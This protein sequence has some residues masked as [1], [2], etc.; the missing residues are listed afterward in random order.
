MILEQRK[1][2]VVLFRHPFKNDST[3]HEVECASFRKIYNELQLTLPID[4]YLF[5]DGDNLVSN[6]SKIPKSDLVYIRAT[7]RGEGGGSATEDEGKDMMSGGVAAWLLAPLTGPLAVVFAIGGMITTLSGYF[8]Y[9]RPGEDTTNIGGSVSGTQ[10]PSIK[11]GTNAIRINQKVPVLL[12][13][14][15]V[16]PWYGAL[17][18]ASYG[19][20]T[21]PGEGFEL[22]SKNQYLNMLFGNTYINADAHL[23]SVYIGEIPYSSY[24]ELDPTD[25]LIEFREDG[26]LPTYYPTRI[27]QD[28]AN[29]LIKRGNTSD[30]PDP[31]EYTRT[32]AQNTKTADLIFVFPTGVFKAANGAPSQWRVGIKVEWKNVEDP[33]TS[34]QTIVDD[35]SYY[36]AVE[37]RRFYVSKTFDNNTPASSEWNSLRQYTF[38]IQRTT[39]DDLQDNSRDPNHSFNSTLYLESLQSYTGTYDDVS[40]PEDWPILPSDQAKLNV[41]SL[42]VKA[43]DQIS[44]EV[45]NVNYEMTAHMPVYT[46]NG[47]SSESGPAYW[48]YGTS[49][50]PASA[51]LYILTS[52]LANSEPIPVANLEERID[53]ESLEVWYQFCEDNE[54]ECN[55]YLVN[56]MTV[57]NVL[58]EICSVGFASWNVIDNRYTIY[59]DTYNNTIT[60]MFTPRN[61]YEYRG[62]KAFNDVP[63]GLK[64]TFVNS[65]RESTTA[66]SEKSEGGFVEEVR[67]VYYD[68]YTGDPRSTDIIH[69]VSTFGAMDPEQ[70]WRIGMYLLA[71]TRLRPETH[72][73]SVDIEHIMCT[74]WDRVVLQH[75]VP[76]FGLTS[77][78]ILAPIESAGDTLGFTSDEIIQFEVGKNYGI[79]VRW[80]DGTITNYDVTNTETDTH[81]ILFETPVTGTGLFFQD[82]LFLIGERG[83]ESIDLLI[84]DIEA[85][86]DHCARITCMEYNES[87]YDAWMI[88]GTSIPPY[89]SRVSNGGGG[90]GGISVNELPSTQETEN[91]TNTI[92]TG[93]A[94]KVDYRVSAETAT[95]YAITT[96]AGFYPDILVRENTTDSI[97]WVNYD[98][99]N[100]IYSSFVSSSASGT[101]LNSVSSKFPKYYNDGAD[102]LYLNVEDYGGS[103]Y[104]KGADTLSN[105]INIFIGTFY[106]FAINPTTEN[107]F[108]FDDTTIYELDSVGFAVSDYFTESILDLTITDTEEVYYI[109]L[110][111]GYVYRNTTAFDNEE[112]FYNGDTAIQVEYAS[113]VATVYI[114]QSSDLLIVKKFAS[115]TDTTTSVSIEFGV[116][117]ASGFAVTD[118]GDL[119][120]AN[121]QSDTL[122]YASEAQV[123]FDPTL[124]A[125]AF[126]HILDGD[127]ALGST[128][129]TN[130]DTADL[131]IIS[132]GDTVIGSGIPD[133]TYIST[134]GNSYFTMTQASTITATSQE[135]GI[136]GSRIILNAN[137]VIVPGSI[138]ARLLSASAINSKARDDNGDHISEFDLDAG[139]MTFRKQDGTKV[140][141]FTP[142]PDP[143]EAN[144]TLRGTLDAGRVSGFTMP[145]TG[146]S[147]T[148]TVA[149]TGGDYTSLSEA[150]E[151]LSRSVMNFQNEELSVIIEIASGYTITEALTIA[152]LDLSW[153]TITGVDAFTNVNQP[154][155]GP[156]LTVINAKAPSLQQ[157]FTNVSGINHVFLEMEGGS[158][159][160]ASTYYTLSGFYSIIEASAGSVITASNLT[161]DDIFQ[162]ITLESGSTF[163]VRFD[164][165]L[166]LDSTNPSSYAISVTDASSFNCSNLNTS[167]TI[168]TLLLATK[169]SYLGCTIDDTSTV[170]TSNFGISC[171]FTSQIDLRSG[172]LYGTYSDSMIVATTGGIVNAGDLSANTPTSGNIL[173]VTTGGLVFA[174]GSTITSTN[175]TTN[176]VHAAG[177]IFV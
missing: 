16:V 98:Q 147:Y 12:G 161:A 168:H 108:I 67:Y 104:L 127:L 142:N 118:A 68:G 117:T 44:G 63:T 53:Y 37:T 48:S 172:D 29:L 132:V 174:T 1:L 134:M 6:Y 139:D 167:G 152:N 23:D 28:D 32:T 50:N 84:S 165:T 56:D 35:L 10:S 120:Y 31:I 41:A 5:L 87:I 101:Q 51:F 96:E 36:Y 122:Y 153:I 141:E 81:T 158:I 169:G 71:C 83:S 38:R 57:E 14:H 151:D 13:R 106:D 52:D 25:A 19:A 111:D 129:V 143:G 131:D 92:V 128:V 144:L 170:T 47:T 66:L 105:G 39:Y 64:V 149:S 126:T 112:L 99:G 135:L 4:Q 89:V 24:G 40:A 124:E 113:D 155:P 58:R 154:S 93:T 145:E 8:L 62:A 125:E 45:N 85:L 140:L 43:T 60:Q 146:S 148:V 33:D 86:D 75:D 27:K 42:R 177:I 138:E 121:T 164:V 21:E 74:R 77:G 162:G 110:S 59:I 116:A 115:D 166:A 72:A 102:I 2:K 76:L 150:L 109:K 34:Y 79:Q 46:G 137:K 123:L 9:T 130:V 30:Y 119:I 88:P 54:L 159:S 22:E 107:I 176:T 90:V 49:Q 103:L 94:S 7:L 70:A 61:S 17:P 173:N 100:Y 156:F 18:Y 114:L 157:N 73:F 3:I 69:D 80:E 26:V 97:T 95:G 78:R 136:A 65:H 91:E 11:G 82:D 55:A 171:G 20:L 133:D 163:I 15:L 175:V 160:F